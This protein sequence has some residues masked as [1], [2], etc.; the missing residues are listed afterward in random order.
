MGPFL[1]P[2]N[3]PGDAFEK[4][5]DENGLTKRFDRALRESL[6]SIKVQETF[7]EVIQILVTHP[8][9]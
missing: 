3:F 6:S 8:T 5:K 2:K 9:R 4:D 1:L 7:P